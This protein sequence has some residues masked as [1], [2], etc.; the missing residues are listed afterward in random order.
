MRVGMHMAVHINE[1][2]NAYTFCM[3]AR[4]MNSIHA[5]MESLIRPLFGM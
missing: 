4:Y 3:H 5:H 1:C 2:A